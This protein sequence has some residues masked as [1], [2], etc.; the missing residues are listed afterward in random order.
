MKNSD[1]MITKSKVVF[2]L[3]LINV[4]PISFWVNKKYDISFSDIF[5]NYSVPYIIIFMCLFIKGGNKIFRTVIIT[6]IM[7]WFIFL[8]LHYLIGFHNPYWG[9]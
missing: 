1:L 5:L 3:V 9:N 2:Y 7:T 8:T 4:V 6:L